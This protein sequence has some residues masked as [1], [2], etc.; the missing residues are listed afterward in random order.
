MAPLPSGWREHFDIATG[1]PYYELIA[2]GEV[3]WER[4]TADM[5]VE[6]EQAPP[7]LP[8][9]WESVWDAG[10][11]AYYYC[12]SELGVSQWEPPSPAAMPHHHQPNVWTD[13]HNTAPPPPFNLP[14]QPMEHAE[15]T[16][17]DQLFQPP[18]IGWS[19]PSPSTTAS[20][21]PKIG[22]ATRFQQMR[23]ERADN[24]SMKEATP[25]PV[26]T[27]EEAL[28]FI[29]ENCGAPRLVTGAALSASDGKVTCT[30]C[31]W[32]GIPSQISRQHMVEKNKEITRKKP[33]PKPPKAK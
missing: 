14:F 16:P 19:A 25:P 17:A 20:S 13:V 10:Y 15:P 24:A 22:I 3:F 9:G 6:E 2:S 29:C 23:K 31:Q 26:M 12:N 1:F 21:Q 30:L 4:P 5:A 18:I 11:Q 27:G 28:Q 8:E 32:V 33:P 7:Q